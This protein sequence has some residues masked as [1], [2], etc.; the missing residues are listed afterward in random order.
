MDSCVRGA[1]TFRQADKARTALVRYVGPDDITEILEAPEQPVHGLLAHTGAFCEITWANS[2]RT[3]ILKH[4]HMCQAQLVKT[5][6]VEIL[7]DTTMDCLAG[8]A[9]QC[10]DEHFLFFEL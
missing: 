5:R 4:R 8:N 1:P 6:R 2:I 9:Q 7:D 3:R 10:A